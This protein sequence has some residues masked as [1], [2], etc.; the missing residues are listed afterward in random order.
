MFTTTSR[1][2]L[3]KNLKSKPITVTSSN[4][5]FLEMQLLKWVMLKASVKCFNLKTSD[6]N[7]KQKARYLQHCNKL[8]Q[9]YYFRWEC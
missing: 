6:A 7:W 2:V 4:T 3:E 9:F 1:K 8:W 5:G